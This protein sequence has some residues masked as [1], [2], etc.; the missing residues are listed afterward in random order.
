MVGRLAPGFMISARSGDGV[1]E[2]IE[3]ETKTAFCIG[4]Q[5]HP[6]NM[7]KK[8][9]VFLKLFKALIAA[10]KSLYIEQKYLKS[11]GKPRMIIEK[12]IKHKN[13]CFNVV[14]DCK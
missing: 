4:V 8:H 3:P 2:A 7:Y 10:F 12:I 1:I 9:D 6:E 14:Y 11:P 13:I 5:F